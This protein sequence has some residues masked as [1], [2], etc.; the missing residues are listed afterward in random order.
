MKGV[1]FFLLIMVRSLERGLVFYSEK[2][3]IYA[4]RDGIIGLC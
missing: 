4:E 1:M 3:G 2:G